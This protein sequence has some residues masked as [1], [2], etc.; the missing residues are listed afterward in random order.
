MQ[1]FGRALV[2]T[3]DNFGKLG[4]KPTHPELLDW[5]AR[6]FIE[7]GWSLKQLHRTI[8]L[9]AA[10]Q[11]SSRINGRNFARDGDN[12][13]IW[14]MEPRRLDVEAWR[15]GLLAVTKS[16]DVTAGGPATQSLLE[17]N[18]R[19]LYSVISRNGD[20]FQSDDFLRLFDFPSAR[21]TS[22]KRHTS[23]VPQQFLFM[24]NSSFMVKR[25]KALAAR[26]NAEAQDNRSRI[27]LAYRLLF[28]RVPTS[29][30]TRAATA[31]LEQAPLEQYAQVLLS[32]NEC[33]FLR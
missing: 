15:D 3:P 4:D 31:F 2:R 32:S 23:I 20:K 10:Y 1:H 28:D 5:L 8:M 33:L 24:M 25:A 11:M 12:R 29:D 17:S 30:E 27:E 6:S 9:S 22:A 18:R 16:L 13:L 26:L 14:R 7:S 19:T 21:A